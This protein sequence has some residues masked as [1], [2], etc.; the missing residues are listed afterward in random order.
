MWGFFSRESVDWTGLER[1]CRVFH[2]LSPSLFVCREEE[3]E[4]LFSSCLR[5][6]PLVIP[7]NSDGETA[8]GV[9]PR[10]CFC[11]AGVSSDWDIF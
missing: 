4:A 8:L 2:L 11:L 1:E 9:A 10:V 6:P 5:C 3:K 7:G